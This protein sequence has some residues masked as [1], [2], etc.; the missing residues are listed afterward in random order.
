[1]DQYFIEDV[2]QVAGTENQCGKWFHFIMT[3]KT[4]SLFY[5]REKNIEA[6]LFLIKHCL[7]GTYYVTDTDV[8]D[9]L[10]LIR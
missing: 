7:S 5:K 4:T 1:M 6:M 2:F 8:S 3:A 10:L 9:A